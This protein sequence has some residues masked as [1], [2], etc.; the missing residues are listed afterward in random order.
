MLKMLNY[1]WNENKYKENAKNA[2]EKCKKAIKKICQKKGG[3]E[4]KKNEGKKKQKQA[5]AELWQAQS[6][7]S[8]LLPTTSYWLAS[9]CC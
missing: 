3:R 4:G 8:S 9:K 6:S 7:E 2:K 5:G 1:C